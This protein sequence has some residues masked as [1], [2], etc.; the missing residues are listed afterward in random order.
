MSIFLRHVLQNYNG[1]LP[2]LNWFHPASYSTTLS[3]FY[4]TPWEIFRTGSILPFTSRPVSFVTK[5]GSVPGYLS[6]IILLPEYELGITILTT[7]LNADLKDQ[8]REALSV[9]LVKAAEAI[10]QND[11]AHRYTGKYTAKDIDSTLALS[12]SSTRSLFISSFVSNSTDFFTSWGKLLDFKSGAGRLQLI[13]TLLYRDEEKQEGEIWRG[14]I[15]PET[16]QN[17]V[18]DDFCLTD[19][20]SLLYAGKPL[21]EVVFWEGNDGRM[22]EVEISAFRVRLKRG[23]ESEASQ[24]RSRT[25]KA[26][27][28]VEEK[29]GER[30]QVL[31]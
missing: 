23:V 9:P 6:Y 8:I 22:S 17:L 4:G 29:C 15:V 31:P 13:P 26:M 28:V 12:Q 10:T 21:L 2:A 16:R 18:W 14:V 30:Q 3:S 5:S 11:L 25:G 19:D 27:L 20:D 1:I 7:G 24:E